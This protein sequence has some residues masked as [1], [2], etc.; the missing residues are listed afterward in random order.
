MTASVQQNGKL[1][2]IW[3][4]NVASLRQALPT[5]PAPLLPPLLP[6]LLSLL[7]SLSPVPLSCLSLLHTLFCLL[8]CLLLCLLCCLI[9]CLLFSFFSLL[10]LC[11]CSS[12]C[13]VPS[14]PSLPLSFYFL[15]LLCCTYCCL[16]PLGLL[17]KVAIKYARTL[18]QR[19]SHSTRSHQAVTGSAYLRARIA[20]YKLWQRHCVAIRTGQVEVAPVP[21]CAPL[22]VDSTRTAGKQEEE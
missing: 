6:S 11:S 15:S 17:I 21:P 16:A 22:W 12:S 20:H 1:Q 2:Q 18:L 19:V 7:L 13:S 5:A 9:S 4:T 10:P 14:P 8:C 3:V